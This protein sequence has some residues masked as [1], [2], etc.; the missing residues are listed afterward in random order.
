MG[1]VLV[2]KA[3]T[4]KLLL[5]LGRHRVYIHEDGTYTCQYADKVQDR[6]VPLSKV[7]YEL[8]ADIQEATGR[9]DKAIYKGS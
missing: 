7:P 2:M 8:Q 9:P 6:R 3:Q 5:K 1:R 4:C